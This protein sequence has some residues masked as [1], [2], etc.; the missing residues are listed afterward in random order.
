MAGPIISTIPTFQAA[1]LAGDSYEFYKKKKKTAGDFMG[2]GV[3]TIVGVSI[4]GA[5]ANIIGSM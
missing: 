1:A 5:T 4:I 3:K 2:Q